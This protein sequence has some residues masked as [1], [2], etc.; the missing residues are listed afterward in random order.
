LNSF[1]I[2]VVLYIVY[3]IKTHESSFFL[4]QIPVI[5]TKTYITFIYHN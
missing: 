1:K 4:L 5:L 2:K 3:L